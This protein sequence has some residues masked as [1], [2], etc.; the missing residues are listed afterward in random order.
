MFHLNSGKPNPAEPC[1]KFEVTAKRVLQYWSQQQQQQQQVE[2]QIFF[3][4]ARP[5]LCRLITGPKVVR[6]DPGAVL[7]NIFRLTAI[8]RRRL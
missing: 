1:R 8:I 2:L 7:S 4:R 6:P 5:E 3:G